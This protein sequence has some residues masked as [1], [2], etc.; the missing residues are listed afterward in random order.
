MADLN[1][2]KIRPDRAIRGEPTMLT[3]DHDIRGLNIPMKDVM[4]AP[5]ITMRRAPKDVLRD[6]LDEHFVRAKWLGTVNETIANFGQ[7][8]LYRS[9]SGLG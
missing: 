9:N 2:R 3:V 7:I 8:V 6:R 1:E 4:E 5:K